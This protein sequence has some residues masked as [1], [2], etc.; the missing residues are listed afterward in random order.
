MF[1]VAIRGSARGRSLWG[2]TGKCVEKTQV[3]RKNTSWPKLAGHER[4]IVSETQ[5]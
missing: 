4:I 2:F 3:C 1:L 5:R